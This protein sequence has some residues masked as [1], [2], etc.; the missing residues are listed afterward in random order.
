MTLLKTLWIIG[1]AIL[2]AIVGAIL[3]GGFSSIPLTILGALVGLVAGALLGKF[4]PFYEWF[5]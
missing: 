5:S 2:G 4:I 1:F 3:I